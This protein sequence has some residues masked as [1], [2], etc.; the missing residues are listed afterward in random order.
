MNDNM[1]VFIGFPILRTHP[2]PHEN[3]KGFMDSPIV[4]TKIT[5]HHFYYTGN[6]DSER[7][8]SRHEWDD[9]NWCLWEG[10]DES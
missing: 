9:G 5:E 2:T 3:Y 7:I 4:I 6:G 8:L 10:T 1:E